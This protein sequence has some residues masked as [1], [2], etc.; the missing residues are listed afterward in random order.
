MVM[1]RRA[2]WSAA[3]A[4]VLIGGLLITACN[5]LPENSPVI[6]ATATPSTTHAQLLEL[7]GSLVGGSDNLADPATG[8][9][10]N[11]E[12]FRVAGIRTLTISNST[13]R[14]V[15]LHD[16]TSAQREAVL[17]QLHASPLTATIV[18]EGGSS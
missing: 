9:L 17:R 6:T 4:V 18:T 10:P 8:R 12:A 14:V 13:I 5:E 15:M 11:T 3:C 2:F 7:A 16:A 1:R